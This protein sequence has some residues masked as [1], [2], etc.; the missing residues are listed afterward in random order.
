MQ[1]SLNGDMVVSLAKSAYLSFIVDKG[2]MLTSHP[3]P[4]VVVMDKNIS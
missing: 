1:G 2:N 4:L 3:A